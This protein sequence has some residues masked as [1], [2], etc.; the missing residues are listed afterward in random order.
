LRIPQAEAKAFIETYFTRFGGVRAYLDSQVA[1]A[2]EHGYVETIFHRRRYIPELR[3]RNFNIRSFGERV[4]TNAP[5]QGSAADL[6]KVAMIRIHDA[7]QSQGLAGQM[8]LQV[9]DELVL[10]APPNEVDAVTS[11]VRDAMEG[12]AK[13]SVP[14]V[15]DLGVGDN[16]LDA[17]A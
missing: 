17:K 2:R 8:L 4:A 14:L 15:V 3:D 5:I 16:W 10:E 13:L 6:I 12:A 7:L 1:Y 9:H 11:I